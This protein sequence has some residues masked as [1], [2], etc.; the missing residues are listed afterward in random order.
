[1]C[2]LLAVAGERAFTLGHVL[3]WARRVEVM[4]FAGY[5]W[6]VAWTAADGIFSYKHPGPL[7][8]DQTSAQRLART[9]LTRA[10]IHLRRPS[11]PSTVSLADT[12]PFVDEARSFAFCHNG[13]FSLAQSFRESLSG[14]LAGQADSEVGFRMVEKSIRAG[15][16]P[17][18]SLVKMHQELTGTANCGYL[19]GDGEL[20]VYHSNPRNPAWTFMRDGMQVLVTGLH[21]PDRSGLDQL[22]PDVDAATR[23]GEGVTVIASRITT[24]S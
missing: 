2:E 9:S 20:L 18:E 23:V 19:G 16:S 4:G 15:K 21:W 17:S 1:M 8:A 3:D 13:F 22:F 11:D 10:L 6:G 5:G 12:Q 7:A 14:Q 24:V